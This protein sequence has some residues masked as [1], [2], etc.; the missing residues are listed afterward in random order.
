MRAENK[1]TTSILLYIVILTI[2]YIER[3]IVK[4][5]SPNQAFLIASSDTTYI[6]S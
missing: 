5:P 3:V 2:H 4:K 6:K 1:E